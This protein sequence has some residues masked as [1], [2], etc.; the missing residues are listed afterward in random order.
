MPVLKQA[1]SYYARRTV[2]VNFRCW[3]HSHWWSALT[4][5]LWVT[6]KD[7]I[8]LT[9]ACLTSAS[10][11]GYEASLMWTDPTLK[12]GS[13]PLRLLV[14]KQFLTEWLCY[15]DKGMRF[16]VHTFLTCHRTHIHL[17]Y[18]ESTTFYFF[19]NLLCLL[20]GIWFDDGQRSLHRHGR[21]VGK[22]WSVLHCS[23]VSLLNCC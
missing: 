22:R 6:A 13:G 2:E 5:R 19:Y 21:R 3:S 15:K 18:G 12:G 11:P 10:Q 23:C 1:R 14:W 8:C 7:T 4:M 17:Q 20:Y 16:A 9:P